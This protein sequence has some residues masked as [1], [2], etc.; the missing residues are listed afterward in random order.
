MSE[1]DLLY[2]RQ[3]AEREI[4]ASREARNAS[5]ARAH[6]LLA[7]YYLDLVYNGGVGSL[8][9]RARRWG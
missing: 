6:A 7:G 1:D 3:R 4:E 5:A 2:Y 8:R 9:E